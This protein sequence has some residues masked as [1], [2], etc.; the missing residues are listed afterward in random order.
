[1]AI[2]TISRLYGSGGSEVAEKV[3]GILNWTLLDNAVVDE[4]ASRLG[5]SPAQVAAREERVSSLAERLASTMAL[6]SQEWLSPI[7]A[8]T[9]PATDEQLLDVT[10]RV[11]DEAISA[12]PVVMVGRGAQSMLAERT[13][14]LHVFCYASR[15]ALIKRSMER[16]NLRRDDAEKLV[17]ET[18]AN[19]EKYVRANW[20]RNWKSHE[21]YHLSVNTDWL[22]I[23]GAAETIVAVAKLRLPSAR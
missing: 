9:R 16:D 22:G 19:R 20:N 11:L 4:V 23:E 18:N 1:M 17:D 13:D 15:P 10:Q 2:I 7:A 3:A 21:N 5:V 8:A 12:G 6:G 14:A